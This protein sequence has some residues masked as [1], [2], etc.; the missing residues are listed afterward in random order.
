MM[1]SFLSKRGLNSVI[2]SSTGLPAFTR[3]IILRGVSRLATN[4]LR[5]LL[6]CNL[7]P[8]SFPKS[9]INLSVFSVVRLNTLI[10]NPLFA[11][12]RARFAPIVARPM[13]P[14]ADLSFKIMF[15]T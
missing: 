5:V 12:L 7:S 1:M 2:M 8:D 13:R 15:V 14:M 6:P 10:E 9:L 11:I 4:S 3:R